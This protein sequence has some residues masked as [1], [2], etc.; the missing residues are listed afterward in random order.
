MN[1]LMEQL[2]SFEVGDSCNRRDMTKLEKKYESILKTKG[3]KAVRNRDV[4]KYFFETRNKNGR[5]TINM[6][7]EGRMAMSIAGQ[8]AKRFEESSDLECSKALRTKSGA[9]VV[10]MVKEG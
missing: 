10:L 5:V 3:E 7:I 2:D 9:R 4:G 1:R 6:I 8:L